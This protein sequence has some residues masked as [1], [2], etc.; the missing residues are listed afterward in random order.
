MNK[1]AIINYVE[2]QFLK[3]PSVTDFR[4]GDTV[5]VSVRI[6]E[7]NSSRIQMYEGVVVA[8]KGHGN[9]RTF[10]VRK[11]SFGV[12]VERI[13]PLYSPTLEKITVV[14]SGRARRAKLYYLRDRMGRASKLEDK[15]ALLDVATAK[16][17]SAAAAVAPS[18]PELVAAKEK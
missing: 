10:T 6:K 14:R 9:A 13:F 8:M 15:D 12:G 16:S 3:A 11:I 2:T 18:A 1:Q 17:G 4:I 5:K 7:G